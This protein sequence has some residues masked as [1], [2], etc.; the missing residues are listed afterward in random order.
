ML[1]AISL[2]LGLF[3]AFAG[4]R[5]FQ[6]EMFLIGFLTF[7][8]VS[9][10][11]LV[12][13]FDANATGESIVNLK[14]EL[15]ICFSLSAE[16]IWILTKCDLTLNVST[17]LAAGTSVMGV[18][19]GL[20]WW[21]IWWFWGVPALSVLPVVLALGFLVAS[22]F[23][24]LPISEWT[25]VSGSFLNWCF[26]HLNCKCSGSTF[27]KIPRSFRISNWMSSFV[28]GFEFLT[29]DFNF[30]SSFTCCWLV[31]PVIC[32]TFTRMVSLVEMT[33][34]HSIQSIDRRK[35]I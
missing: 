22:I 30:W 12:N 18:L 25:L 13:H 10:V 16:W 31:V 19:G 9:Y 3:V 20:L 26:L 15:F 11:V 23:F 7:A 33:L 1:C 5:Y 28:T 35:K 27:S 14:V 29:H 6:I 21:F 17:G 8:A 32:V 4:H 24:Y 34:T 2:F